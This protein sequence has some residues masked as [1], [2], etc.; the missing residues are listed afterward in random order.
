MR[1]IAHLSQL[2]QH[3]FFVLLHSHVFVGLLT[4]IEFGEGAE[5]R[6]SAK[7]GR[8]SECRCEA[9]CSK[10]VFVQLWFVWFG[11]FLLLLQPKTPQNLDEVCGERLH[12]FPRPHPTDAERASIQT[13]AAGT[14]YFPDW[15]RYF[16]VR[17][18]HLGIRTV[19]LSFSVCLSHV[20]HGGNFLARVSLCGSFRRPIQSQADPHWQRFR[21]VSQ[22]FLASHS[23]LAP[24]KQLRHSVVS[25]C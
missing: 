11:C 19:P 18:P 2:S 6:S 4:F 23:N 5:G 22:H 25:V 1:R 3:F 21:S 13:A 16:Q 10:H 15:N 12:F 9:S 7:G 8:A 17:P 24:R 14:V 20:P